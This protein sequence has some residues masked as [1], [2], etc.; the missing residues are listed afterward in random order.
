MEALAHNYLRTRVRHFVADTT[1]DVDLRADWTVAEAT[2]EITTA[3]GLPAVDSENHEQHYELFLRRA[4][5]SGELLRPAVPLA[6]VVT[7]GDELTPMPEVI[8]GSAVGR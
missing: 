6:D 2:Q 5:G 1:T 8:P 4:D 3:L 7:E